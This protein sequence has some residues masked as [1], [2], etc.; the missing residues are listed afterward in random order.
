MVE[1]ASREEAE[2]I[3]TEFMELHRVHWPSFEG[4]SEVRPIED[5]SGQGRGPD[6]GLA[7]PPSRA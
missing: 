1:V 7:G 3:A 2:K 6:A 5:I 4:E